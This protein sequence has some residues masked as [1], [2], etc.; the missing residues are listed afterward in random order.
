MQR[1]HHKIEE[2][3]QAYQYMLITEMAAGLAHEIKNPL[4]GIQ[5]AV[6][7]LIKQRGNL[8]PTVLDS[9]K[10]E[11][12]RIDAAMHTILNQSQSFIATVTRTSLNDVVH[13]TI[14]FIH[15]GTALLKGKNV[16]IDYDST[17]DNI[18][19][20]IAATQIEVVLLELIKNS[21]DA[22]K[23]DG[24]ITVRLRREGGIHDKGQAFIEV[25][26][27]GEGITEQNLSNI[28]KP[29]FTTKQGHIGLGLPAAQRIARAHNGSISISST[30]G[31]G[32]SVILGIPI[33]HLQ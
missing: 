3:D 9:I 17:L 14:L 29:F 28:F 25:A 21:L 24:Q 1:Q 23:K 26:D 12:S 15:N 19:A 8:D 2:L 30:V 32:T 13:D 18:H 31:E 20:L 33:W 5:G 11:V 4:A 22:I 7:I 16:T 10:R 27:T 6:D